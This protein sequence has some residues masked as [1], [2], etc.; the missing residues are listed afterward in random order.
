MLTPCSRTSRDD[1]ARPG[2]S[3]TKSA[4][5]AGAP[6]TPGDGGRPPGT[7]VGRL[8]SGRSQVRAL[9]GALCPARLRRRRKP[10]P[11]HLGPSRARPFCAQ[12]LTA[13]PSPRGARRPA[14]AR[15]GSP[16]RGEPPGTAVSSAPTSCGVGEAG[17]RDQ[18]GSSR[19]RWHDEPVEAVGVGP[20][21]E[22]PQQAVLATLGPPQR[23]EVGLAL[24]ACPGRGPAP[25][26]DD[27]HRHD[28]PQDDVPQDDVPQD[29]RQSSGQPYRACSRRPTGPQ[30]N[31]WLATTSDELFTY[32]CP[33]RARRR[34]APWCLTSGHDLQRDHDRDGADG[35][36]R[37]RRCRGLTQQPPGQG[38]SAGQD[39][40]AGGGPA[41]RRRRVVPVGQPLAD[42]AAEPPR[43]GGGRA[44]RAA[45]AGQGVAE[46]IESRGVVEVVAP[47]LASSWWIMP[48]AARGR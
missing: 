15:A 45:A 2:S 27:R 33:A 11:E 17:Q 37:R 1:P 29:I 23:V 31:P 48:R 13:V 44:G 43:R 16:R 4:H 6:A 46:R 28:V 3:G 5:A 24:T 47:R 22:L 42:G 12:A 8:L 9:P 36:G 26:T 38:W 10:V 25:A 32:V 14:R 35:R 41:A 30:P 20:S 7:G 18:A 21:Q 39:P 40:S 34:T 19:H